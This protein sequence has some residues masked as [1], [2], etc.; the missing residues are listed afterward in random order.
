MNKKL[1]EL[2]LISGSIQTFPDWK[3]NLLRQYLQEKKL[4]TITNHQMAFLSW[5]KGLYGR[6]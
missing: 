2:Y 1:Y 4:T 3:G 5:V 6:D